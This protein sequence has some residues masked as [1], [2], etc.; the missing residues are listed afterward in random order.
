MKVPN[1]K[2]FENPSGGRRYI[3]IDGRTDGQDEGNRAFREYTK[4]PKRWNLQVKKLEEVVAI[5]VGR[6]HVKNSSCSNI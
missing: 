4:A 5:W 1:I 2:F 6:V 3:Q